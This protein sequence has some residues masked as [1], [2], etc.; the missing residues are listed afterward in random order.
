MGLRVSSPTSGQVSSYGPLEGRGGGSE[1]SLLMGCVVHTGRLIACLGA[2][3]LAKGNTSASLMH[4]Y[5]PPLHQH[6]GWRAAHLATP[7]I[8]LHIIKADRFQ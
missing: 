3:W 4:N 8:S 7:P 2:D 1:V 6:R 5:P